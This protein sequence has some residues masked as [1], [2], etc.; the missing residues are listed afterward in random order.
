MIFLHDYIRDVT[1]ND[2]T[3]CGIQS[4]RVI[5]FSFLSCRHVCLPFWSNRVMMMVLL[6]FCCRNVVLIPLRFAVCLL[7]SSILSLVQ[8]CCLFSSLSCPCWPVHTTQDSRRWSGTQRNRCLSCLSKYN[9]ESLISART[10]GRYFICDDRSRIGSIE[11][12]AALH[13]STHH[14]YTA[15]A[16]ALS[17]WA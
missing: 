15:E 5:S 3:E 14:S 13:C 2:W 6:L 16:T 4:C 8:A 9:S 12:V 7:P 1:E 11:K 17:E 10:Q